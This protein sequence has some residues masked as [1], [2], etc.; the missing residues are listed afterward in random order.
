MSLLYDQ[1]ANR[2]S[3]SIGA[4]FSMGQHRLIPGLNVLMIEEKIRKREIV[5]MLKS[6]KNRE[7][8]PKAKHKIKPTATDNEKLVEQA[9]QIEELKLAANRKMLEKRV[10]EFLYGKKHKAN[11]Y[12]PICFLITATALLCCAPACR[13]KRIE[14]NFCVETLAKN[15]KE[16][17]G[18]VGHRSKPLNIFG[19][20]QLGIWLE[21]AK[22]KITR[23]LASSA[24]IQHDPG[25]ILD[26]QI[27]DQINIDQN[28]AAGAEDDSH[29]GEL[30]NSG[31]IEAI[32]HDDVIMIDIDQNGNVEDGDDSDDSK[33]DDEEVDID[34]N[35]NVEDGDDSDDS[36]LDDEEVDIDP[37]DNVEDGDDSDG[38]ELDDEEVD[39]E[40]NST[41]E[42]E[43]DSNDDELGDEEMDIE[44]NS[45]VEDEDVSNDSELDNEIKDDIKSNDNVKDEDGSDEA[46]RTG[47]TGELSET[48]SSSGTEETIHWHTMACLH[49]LFTKNIE[50]LTDS[51]KEE[52][53]RIF[54]AFQEPDLS[55]RIEFRRDVLF[56]QM[57]NVMAQ[58]FGLQAMLEPEADLPDHTKIP[59]KQAS[60]R[61]KT[62]WTRHKTTYQPQARTI[63]PYLLY[64]SG[65][66]D[67]VLGL[68]GKEV[69]E[70][71]SSFVQNRKNPIY[72][73]DNFCYVPSK[74]GPNETPSKFYASRGFKPSKT[75]GTLEP[76]VVLDIEDPELETKATS[77]SACLIT[78]CDK[79]IKTDAFTMEKLLKL[80]GDKEITTLRQRPQPCTQNLKL[81]STKQDFIAED[82]AEERLL[83]E[84]LEN[85]EYVHEVAMKSFD[86]CK[87]SSPIQHSAIL[88][89]QKALRDAQLELKK[90]EGE[91]YPHVSYPFITFGSNIDIDDDAREQMDAINQ[92]PEFTLPNRR[93][94]KVIEEKLPGINQVQVYCKGPGSRTVAHYEN[95]GIGSINI[96]LGP[97]ACVWYCISMK[98]A[99]DLEKLLCSKNC[100]LY[101]SK[102]WPSE[103]ELKDHG[104]SYSKFL[105]QPGEM[106]FVN[107]GTYHWVQSNGFATNISWNI[108]LDDWTQL[109]STALSNDDTAAHGYHTVLPVEKFIWNI[110]K[111]QRN[112]GTEFAKV[113]KQMLTWRLCFDCALEAENVKCYQVRKIEDLITIYDNYE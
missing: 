96:N 23:N 25:L 100:A 26:L 103:N 78:N 54:E 46:R 102:I 101:H 75:Y 58:L 62:K 11:T 22:E 2:D 109:V 41:V 53:N 80:C 24:P 113:A 43:Y 74:R 17:I 55:A 105:Q 48:D 76:V 81:Y 90:K 36:E 73:S 77:L 44:S 52:F 63:V 94:M 28:N 99:A 27:D 82:I 98:Y 110:A 67:G 47:T 93:L 29:D 14:Y 10:V 64:T 4:F 30:E 95:Q 60:R 19:F 83:R 20:A 50:N 97:D 33:L 12:T 59:L 92:L 31:Q 111:E 87:S 65:F 1:R 13:E 45:T 32:E 91:S 3:M 42:V 86:D 68:T 89:M 18:R 88:K 79:K 5:T 69:V 16:H 39:I 72:E 15:I 40:S 56:V 61:K 66:K 106:V 7:S 6:S 112:R 57:K 108:L 70:K 37:N 71:A 9:K 51:Q 38:G 21:Q 8:N 34:P 107:T 104:I 85:H 49:S 84:V 35:D